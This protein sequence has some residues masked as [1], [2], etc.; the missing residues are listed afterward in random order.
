MAWACLS[1]CRFTKARCSPNFGIASSKPRC[2]SSRSSGDIRETSSWRSVRRM[3]ENG[4]FYI[5]TVFVLT[6]ATVNLELPRAVI[7]N[8]LLIATVLQLISIPV[9]G[10]LSDAVGRR[11]VYL[12][13]A[14]A[15][16]AFAFPFFWLIN[17][18]SPTWIGVAISIA[19][20][21]QSAM[22]CAAS[23]LFFRTV[24]DGRPL[25][26]RFDRV[27]VGLATSRRIGS[28]HLHFAA[29]MGRRSN[30]GSGRLPHC[31]LRDHAGVGLAG[32][33]DASHRPRQS[34]RT[35]LMTACRNQNSTWYFFVIL[36]RMSPKPL[37]MAWRPRVRFWLLA[38][39]AWI[40]MTGYCWAEE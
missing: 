37:F 9:F 32:H 26:R 18:T 17:T 36:R 15:L 20:I 14:V 27:S 1:A 2:R 38:L 5:F 31:A 6:Y 39:F 12:G 7:L 33:R 3:A 10:A 16:A 19:L 22:Y 35:A 29:A 21:A 13:G 4:G 23:G 28:A 8:C 40:C 11:P 34:Q 25:Y 24:R 30:L